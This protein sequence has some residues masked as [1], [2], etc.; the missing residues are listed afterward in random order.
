LPIPWVPDSI[1][2]RSSILEIEENMTRPA[3]FTLAGVLL[4]VVLA[5]GAGGQVPPK[6][7]GKQPGN[8]PGNNNPG[9]Q[10][11]EAPKARPLP[12]DERLLALHRDFVKKAETLAKEYEGDKDWGKARAVYEEILKLVPQY[13][14]A[15]T[16][17]DEMLSREATAKTVIVNIKANDGW[18][19]TG[20]ELLPG[21]PIQIA[22][23][24]TWTFLLEVE[25]NA[26]GI[27]IP[28]ELKDFNPGCLV[29]FITN[30][31]V[32][33]KE[34]KPFVVGPEKQMIEEQGG[35][36]YLRMYDVDPSD[37]KGFLKVEIRG[38]FKQEK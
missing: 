10:A 1:R 7:K 19:D 15:N 26:E 12:E 35:R 25:T 8:N 30:G 16:K 5:A 4:S 33:P 38:T 29:G 34:A 2:N 3:L 27:T 24:G 31:N 11:G 17:R 20:I 18:Q 21:R 23:T 32:D 14:S 6:G 36:L 37:N 22:A 28:K 13:A 9:N